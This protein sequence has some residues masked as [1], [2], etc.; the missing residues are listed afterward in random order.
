VGARVEI[1]RVRVNRMYFIVL[2]IL[3][4]SKEST[5]LF[6]GL[7]K[8]VSE[9]IEKEERRSKNEGWKKYAPPWGLD[10]IE[11]RCSICKQGSPTG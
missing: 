6:F 11:E 9:K 8:F 10:G 3:G 1:S 2:F 4:C 5:S 7:A